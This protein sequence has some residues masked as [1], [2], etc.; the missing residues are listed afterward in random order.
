MDQRC[1]L[2]SYTRSAWLRLT[3]L[4]PPSTTRTSSST[5]KPSSARHAFHVP[6]RCGVPWI[7]ATR[8]L[9]LGVASMSHWPTRKSNCATSGGATGASPCCAWLLATP[10]SKVAAT[11]TR[12]NGDMARAL[13][14]WRWAQHAVRRR[15]RGHG[16]AELR[17]DAVQRSCRPAARRLQWIHLGRPRDFSMIQ[18]PSH[19]VELRR[20][21]KVYP[22]P[23]GGFTALSELDLRIERGEFEIGRAS[24]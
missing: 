7:M 17:G 22:G 24:C 18:N 3:G 10:A 2:A 19:A 6:R 13:G 21:S 11:R 16:F 8:P 15:L 12:R 9:T 4:P 23:E 5:P 14:K 1:A 20:A